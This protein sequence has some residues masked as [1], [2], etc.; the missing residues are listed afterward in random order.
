MTMTHTSFLFF[1][2]LTQNLLSY[3][4]G[5]LTGRECV[6]AAKVG[7]EM[8]FGECDDS[9]LGSIIVVELRRLR[10]CTSR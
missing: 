9:T 10:F 5:L 3:L 4:Q 8:F 2:S 1:A 7:D 6:D